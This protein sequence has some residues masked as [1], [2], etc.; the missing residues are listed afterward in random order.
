MER[1]YQL[2][3]V[4]ENT[5]VRTAIF[6]LALFVQSRSAAR[7]VG[8]TPMTVSQIESRTTGGQKRRGFS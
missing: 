1:T 7:L 3:G 6:T 8:R 5:F 2:S 4:F